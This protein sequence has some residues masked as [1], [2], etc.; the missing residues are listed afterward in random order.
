M[1]TK[2]KL[3]NMNYR[4]SIFKFMGIAAMA[5]AVTSCTIDEAQDVP[6]VMLGALEKE[7]TLEAEATVRDLDLYANGEYRLERINESEDWL[8]FTYGDIVVEDGVSKSKITFDATFNEGFKRKAGLVL[9]SEADGRRDTL[10]VKQKALKEAKLQFEGASITLPG[11]GGEQTSPIVSNIPFEDVTV[12]ITYG[13]EANVGWV[14]SIVINDPEDSEIEDRQ[15][16]MTLAANPSEEAPRAAN[17][18]MSFTDGWGDEQRVEFNLLQ[19]TSKETF[20]DPITMEDF[21]LNYTT[22]KVIE[23]YVLLEG[24]VVSHKANLNAGEPEQLTTST[25]NYDLIEQTVYLQTPDG[26]RGIAVIMETPED[27]T[28]E[29]WDHVQLLIHG[30]KGVMLENP[31]RYQLTGVNKTMITKREAGTKND[32]TA[33]NKSVGQLT[34]ADIYTF[35]NL[36]NVYFPVRKGS[37]FPAN[38]GYSIESGAHRNGKYPRLL[39]DDHGD[40]IYLFTNSNCKFRS[41]GRCLPYGSGVIS[42]VIVHER[43]ARFTWRDGADP[44][45]TADDPTLGNIGR[46]GIR[47]QV[48]GDVFDNMPASVEDSK[49]AILA[50]YRWMNPD[51]DNAVAAPTYGSNGWFTHTHQPKYTGDETIGFNTATYKQYM[52]GAG[53]YPYLGPIG[54]S[55]SFI[56]GGN[57]GNVNGCGM[58]ID[59]AKEHYSNAGTLSQLISHNPDGSIEFLGQYATNAY[60]G[61]GAAGHPDS[62]AVKAGNW[63]QGITTGGTLSTNKANPCV[64]INYNGTTSNATSMR[65]KANANAN[66]WNAFANKWW[67]DYE[68][69]F[70]YAWLLNIDLTSISAGQNP[71]IQF[72]SLNSSNQ[73]C[74]RFWA[75]EWSTSD[76]Q[77]GTWNRFAEYDIPDTSSWSNTL[78]S[79]NTAFKA[80]SFKIPAEACGKNI[81]I[82]LIPRNDLCSD[83]GDYANDR[84]ENGTQGTNAVEYIAVRYTK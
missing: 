6:L 48:E 57:Y 23:E 64:T 40:D 11:A 79:S 19:R 42:G 62:D 55:P 36:Q 12:E 63:G 70:V 15:M 10:Y 35:V 78:Y 77:E 34:D 4:N 5:L 60:A 25:I 41:N 44:A 17:V 54:T 82:R 83:G 52:N 33:K 49:V 50:E 43:Y 18:V 9:C 80:M 71:V 72:S 21:C 53:N 65:G 26:S 74:P 13:D 76:D 59:T 84:L 75:V 66:C 29:Q 7:I 27:N 38:G 39:V 30:T 68:N 81:Y 32:I 16:V 1:L 56:F 61:H 22:G 73:Y 69:D 47:P 51:L 3:K 45:E 31:E 37:L 2:L 24:I 8:T 58:V 20:G 67:W 28:F 46:Y 14:E